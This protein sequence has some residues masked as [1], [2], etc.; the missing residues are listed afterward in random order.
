MPQKP[1]TERIKRAKREGVPFAVKENEQERTEKRSGHS[2]KKS[3]GVVAFQPPPDRRVRMKAPPG[4][5]RNAK[6]QTG[7]QEVKADSSSQPA[8]ESKTR[9]VALVRGRK[10]LPSEMHIRHRGG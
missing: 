2:V 9:H 7:E 8:W 4:Y 3:R 1:L 5:G 6:S 10:K